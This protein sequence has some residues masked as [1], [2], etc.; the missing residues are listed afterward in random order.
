MYIILP[1]INRFI[2]DNVEIKY[3]KLIPTDEEI[4]KY[5]I[6]KTWDWI[7]CCLDYHESRFLLIA[8]VL[9]RLLVKQKLNPF[10]IWPKPSFLKKVCDKIS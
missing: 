5:C 9:T 1:K 4:R 3:L 6:Q 2:E 10:S 8:L 7:V